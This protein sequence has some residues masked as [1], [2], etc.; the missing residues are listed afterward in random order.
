MGRDGLQGKEDREDGPAAW[1]NPDLVDVWVLILLI[2]GMLGLLVAVVAPDLSDPSIYCESLDEAHQPE[3]RLDQY[4]SGEYTV[5]ERSE[6]T[7]E[8]RQEF[9]RALNQSVDFSED[10][11][12][13]DSDFFVEGSAIY[14][15]DL[16]TGGA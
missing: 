3:H 6:L 8:Q 4:E 7:P 10:E 16:W 15:C 11:W 5:L 13:M 9:T 2:V 14:Y 1:R 12:P